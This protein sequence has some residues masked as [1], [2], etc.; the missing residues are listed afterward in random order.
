MSTICCSNAKQIDLGCHTF[1]SN[2]YLDHYREYLNNLVHCLNISI[3]SLNQK[4]NF[5]CPICTTNPYCISPFVLYGIIDN[6]IKIIQDPNEYYILCLY[7]Y[8]IKYCDL[9]LSGIPINFNIC[10]SC[11]KLEI[12]NH[13]FKICSCDTDF[14]EEF[15]YFEQL[16]LTYKNLLVSSF[17]NVSEEQYYQE[18]VEEVKSAENFI[19]E[20]MMNLEI[21]TQNMVENKQVVIKKNTKNEKKALIMQMELE[22]INE[23]I[24][25]LE[26]LQIESLKRENI[27]VEKI[28]EEKKRQEMQNKH[29]ARAEELQNNQKE[30]KNEELN[31]K[32]LKEIEAKRKRVE[33]K[34]NNREYSLWQT[35]DDMF[36]KFRRG[37]GLHGFQAIYDDK[38]HSVFR[39]EYPDSSMFAVNKS[40]LT[41]NSTV[42]NLQDNG[43]EVCIILAAVSNLSK[44][45]LTLRKPGSFIQLYII[46]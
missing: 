30:K 38:T 41:R 31:T 12:D 9:Y 40:Y 33:E 4:I 29:E 17:F 22:R 15:N 13:L 14:K 46:F 7:Q 20:G 34:A 26:K 35:L 18:K 36:K 32:R 16:Y 37:V 6:Q 8:A 5:G 10:K 39:S 25:E 28:S 45:S 19:Q 42:I 21:G 24:R 44:S 43:Q 2:H 11:G 1:C 27:L 3:N 23:N